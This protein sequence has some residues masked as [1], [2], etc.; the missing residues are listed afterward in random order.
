VTRATAASIN[1]RRPVTAIRSGRHRVHEIASNRRVMGDDGRVRGIRWTRCRDAALR[2]APE[3]SI[4]PWLKTISFWEGDRK[5]VALHYY[6]V[7]PTSYDQTG[8]VTSDFV[9]IARE[10]LSAREGV[11]HIYFTECAGDIT[12]GKYN[13]GVT[14]NRE[15]FTNRILD[16][17]VASEKKTR[18][19][20][21]G[22]VDWRVESVILP[23]RA[24][25]L[26]QNLIAT[27]HTSSNKA[28]SRAALILAYR[29]RCKAKIPLQVT[30]LHL[31]D[32]L[33]SIHTPGESFIAYQ[34]YA[35]ELR[36]DACVV[37]PSY[38]DC[39]PGYVTLSRSFQEGGYE[40]NDS[41]CS[42]QSEAILREAIRNV[43]AR[44]VG[45]SS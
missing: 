11:P 39:G 10:R 21:V 13:D 22:P 45:I 17:M 4:D 44:R 36:P 31:G 40:P 7:H 8:H 35:Q 42:P 16:A 18:P 5:L 24:D 12:P 32:D 34:L 23:P 19:H 33:L 28:R 9:G 29:R 27:L 38:A 25:H 14:D 20:A 41:F 37:V 3:G 1:E 43:A 6:A 30:A 15:L 2:A 26:E